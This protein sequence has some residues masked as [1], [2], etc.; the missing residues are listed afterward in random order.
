MIESAYGD[1]EVARSATVCIDFDP[2]SLDEFLLQL[3]TVE[4][5][6]QGSAFM[7]IRS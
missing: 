4:A 7:A 2:A 3:K 1:K 5:A 6:H